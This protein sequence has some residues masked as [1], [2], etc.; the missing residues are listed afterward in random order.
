[1]S[2]TNPQLRQFI[3]QFFSDEELETLCFDYFPEA[4]NDFGGGMSK[5]RK[6]IV[7]IGHCE[8]RG[9]LEDLRAAVARERAEAWNRQFAAP[10][11]GEKPGFSEKTRFPIER[12]PRQIF[13]SHATADAAFARTLAGDLQAKGWRVWI[14]PDSIRPGEKWVEAIDRGLETSGVFVVVLTPAAVASRWVNT[15]TDAAIE[16][17]HEGVVTFIPLDVAEC[18]PKRLWR[19][20]QYIPFRG[21]YEIGL[22][23]LLRQLDGEEP[24]PPAHKPKSPQPKTDPNRRIHEKTGIELVRIPAGPFLYGS[25]DADEMARDNEKPQRKIDLPEYWVGRYPVT[26]AQYKRFVDATGRPAPRRWNGSEPPADK[27]DH[28]VVKVSWDDAK[29]FCDW[30]GLALPTEEQWEKAAR[31]TDGRIWP[32]GDDP[33]T[34]KHCNFGRYIGITTSVGKFSPR[35]DSIYGCAD[36]AG[37]AWEWT[38]SWY[39]EDRSGRVERGGSWESGAN[40]IKVTTRTSDLPDAADLNFNVGFRVV[41]LLSDPGF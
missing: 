11:A 26:N 12:D 20:Y 33:P 24:A 22:D 1:M 3:N 8:R 2:P 9:R 39:D 32:W 21:S 14:A 7:L 36:M 35:G 27:L 38:A 41:E 34:H 15:E 40:S 23:A 28:P 31:G 18:Q 30:A 10:P 6:V 17:Q 5:N 13:L 25:S 19:Q 16:M 29:A 37:N 4:S